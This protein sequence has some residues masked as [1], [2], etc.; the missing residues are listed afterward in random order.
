M[1][2]SRGWK[3]P[4]KKEVWYNGLMMAWKCALSEG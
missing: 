3:E 4:F 2:M 1:A